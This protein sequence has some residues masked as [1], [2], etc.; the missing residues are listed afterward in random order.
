MAKK[1]KSVKCTICGDMI[2][3]LA[4]MC[5]HKPSL[6][7]QCRVD[8]FNRWSPYDGKFSNN[9]PNV[10]EPD[11]KV[12]TRAFTLKFTNGSTLHIDGESFTMTGL[13]KFKE[14]LSRMKRR[15]EEIQN[16]IT[17]GEIEQDTGLDKIIE[18][19]EEIK[20]ME[21]LLKDLEK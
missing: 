17:S 21:R 13:D 8:E 14:V 15:K 6:C 4:S 7:S 9:W 3:I 10:S 12:G 1:L 5:S 11:V 18:L 20:P 16:Q 19:N 2:F